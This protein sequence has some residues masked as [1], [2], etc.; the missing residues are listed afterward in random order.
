MKINSERIEIEMASKRMTQR[1]LSD[2]AGVSRR[3]ICNIIKRGTCNPRTAGRIAA[4]LGIPVEQ[5]VKSE[6]SP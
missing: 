4:G 2:A 5:I 6:V 3:N 1:D